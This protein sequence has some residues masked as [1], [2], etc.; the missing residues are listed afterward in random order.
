MLN[1][2]KMPV[3]ADSAISLDVVKKY[4][5]LLQFHPNE[6]FFP[7]SIEYL[8]QGSILRDH[9]NDKWGIPNPTQAD[10]QQYN[11]DHYYVDINP[12]QYHGM[13]T[14]RKITAPMYYAVQAFTDIVEITYIFLYAYQGGQTV[15]GAGEYL[16]TP[17]TCIVNDFAIHQGDI[18]QIV[19]RLIPQGSDNYKVLDVVYSAH[20]DDTYFTSQRI[21][22]SGT[23]P[24]VNVAL[25]LHGSY[26]MHAQG[27]TIVD[28]NY[29]A[30]RVINSV[31]GNGVQWETYNATE[32]I[33]LGLDTENKPINNQVWAAF[34]GRLGKK[35]NNNFTRA[36]YYNRSSLNPSDAKF[37]SMINW[38]A[39]KLSLYPGHIKVGNGPTGPGARP[40]I[41]P[42]SG[43]RI[44]DKLVRVLAMDNVGQRSS[45]IAWLMGDITESGRGNIIQLWANKSRLGMIVYGLDEN[46]HFVQLFGSS[47]ME[48]GHGAIA[49]FVLNIYGDRRK[50][51]VQVW[52]NNGKIGMIMYGAD[53]YGNV[54]TLW[55]TPDIG[56]GYGA[57]A[58]LTGDIT[59][60]Q[61]DEIVQLWNN[62]G[63]LGLI[64][65]GYNND[66]GIGTLWHSSNM[67]QGSGA[68]GWLAGDV[69]GDGKDEIIQLWNNNGKLGIIM[70]GYDIY[71]GIIKE[72]WNTDNTGNGYGAVQWLIGDINGDG[73][74][75]VIQLWNN[76]G[77]LGII[78]YGF[79]GKV[80]LKQLWSTDNAC[81]GYGAISWQIGDIDGNDKDEII[82]LWDNNGTLSMIV[83]GDNGKNGLETLWYSDNVGEGSGAVAWLMGNL[84]SDG[85]GKKEIFQLWDN[86]GYLG[87]IGY[88]S[89]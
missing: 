9:N 57:V 43:K 14:S 40:W 6:I 60:N 22:W 47:D 88:G 33:Q 70:Y 38:A 55:N 89:L 16:R 44:N 3:T 32:I 45:A 84:K 59:G 81:Q 34:K 46:N 12:A 42:G 18:E 80:G 25:N 13:F 7:C 66:S 76:N 69:N 4:A 52:N 75:E 15:W 1:V 65:Y 61:K 27:E 23:H 41:K 8:L 48:Q 64:L 78:V 87:I 82:Q 35:Q 39:V 10:L 83:Y 17:F 68:V 19:V 37:V 49:W 79:D 51:I 77:M 29:G 30:I 71:Q 26:S 73:N 58:W 72:L 5:P 24:V 86:N 53:M 67:G 85:N 62:N 11:E 50:E 20:G 2:T 28:L 74:D 36:T 21:K 31:S 63:T 54:R 56:Q